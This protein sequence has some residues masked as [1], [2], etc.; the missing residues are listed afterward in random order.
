MS[1]W[2]LR[3]MIP[4]WSSFRLWTEP[5]TVIILTII[6]RPVKQTFW[7]PP[8]QADWSGVFFVWFSFNGTLK[9]YKTFKEDCILKECN[10]WIKALHGILLI[11]TAWLNKNIPFNK[12]SKSLQSLQQANACLY[13]SPLTAK[14][15]YSIWLSEG[16][17]QPQRTQRQ[18]DLRW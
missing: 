1:I 17:V 15:S 7:I 9:E 16:T 14:T 11:A 2:D 18:R 13:I 5:W 6:R 10:T 12:C 3:V 8:Q 4:L